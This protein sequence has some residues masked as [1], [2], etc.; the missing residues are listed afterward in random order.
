MELLSQRLDTQRSASSWKVGSAGPVDRP[1]RW[2]V[3]MVFSVLFTVFSKSA[4]HPGLY[5][6][7]DRVLN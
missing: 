6:T 2:S 5:V 3:A 1:G 7:M 4:C